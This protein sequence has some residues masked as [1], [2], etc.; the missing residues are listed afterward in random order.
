MENKKSPVDYLI[1]ELQPYIDRRLVS[2]LALHII[3][4]TALAKEKAQR[5]ADYTKGHEDRE[6]NVF[7]IPK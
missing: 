2:D 1:T 4:E 6:K 5:L 7:V 3:V